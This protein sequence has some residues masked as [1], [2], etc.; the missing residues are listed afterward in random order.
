MAPP[1]VT[2]PPV[3]PPP[4]TPPP[5]ASA[6]TVS[7]RFT[8][9]AVGGP[10]GLDTVA[11]N[12]GTAAASVSLKI[13]VSGTFLPG[14]LEA[15]GGG[16]ACSAYVAKPVA[17]AT[18][19]CTGSVAAKSSAIVTVSSGSS[20]MSAAAGQTVSAT[21]SLNPGAQLATATATYA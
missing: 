10:I 15:K 20:I 19:T 2:P 1:P 6:T 8:A 11:A 14:Y 17:K 12:D 5:P 7:Q 9:T 16:L 4:V 21:A 18:F 13:D 3:T